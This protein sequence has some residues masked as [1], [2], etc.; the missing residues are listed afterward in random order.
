MAKI[1]S[2]YNR[3][4]A[5]DY[6]N[7]N[8]G[9][10]RVSRLIQFIHATL[11]LATNQHREL[12]EILGSAT[13]VYRN[14]TVVIGSSATFSCATNI[15]KPCFIWQYRPAAD[16][17][18]QFVCHKYGLNVFAEPKCNVTL[19][20]DNRTSLLTVNGVRLNDSG[21]Y[22]CTECFREEMLSETRLA[23]IGQW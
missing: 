20:N 7:G 1:L 17:T 9:K 8:G 19:T 13:S 5:G 14:T 6:E 22:S 3:L 15:S 12:I 10:R 4:Q 21:L 18:L 23:V 16:H 11:Q 2:V